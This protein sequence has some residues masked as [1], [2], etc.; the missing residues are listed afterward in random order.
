[1]IHSHKLASMVCLTD[2]L[3]VSHVHAYVQHWYGATLHIVWYSFLAYVTHVRVSR[4][5]FLKPIQLEA[6]P[7]N[8]KKA[9]LRICLHNSF[10]RLTL[11]VLSCLKP[12]QHFAS[13][14]TNMKL[15]VISSLLAG[16]SAFVAQPGKAS[17]ALAASKYAD[18]LGAQTPLGYWDPL[19]VMN[20]NND[21][22]FELFRDVEITH[23]RVAMLAFTG[24][25][26]TRAGIHFSGDYEGVAYADIPPGVAAFDVMPIGLQAKI[27][28]TVFFLECF[29]RSIPDTGNEFVGD[30]RNGWIDFGWDSFDAETKMKKRAV[31][32]NNGRAAMMGIT[33]LIVHEQ[34]HTNLPI[35]GQL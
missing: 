1:M 21:V 27:W 23:G 3:H 28:A 30:Y 20:V 25:I 24:Q 26:V 32:L 8:S 34:L 9:N 13:I 29:M 14:F 10:F 6:N 12:R 33:G 18:E 22:K 15:L 16:A 7:T 11:F 5:Y 35:I 4:K 19:G 31:E 2:L 17:S